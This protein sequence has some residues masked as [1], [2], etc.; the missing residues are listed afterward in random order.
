MAER[1]PWGDTAFIGE[2]MT[3]NG[4]PAWTYRSARY[5]EHE[6]VQLL[7][8]TWLLVGHLS[9]IPMRGD[10]ITLDFENVRIVVIRGRDG[11]VRAFENTCRHMGSRLFEQ[12]GGNCVSRIRCPFHG[13]AYNLE[14]DL[15]ETLD[16][17]DSVFVFRKSVKLRRYPLFER[18][19]LLFV[20]PRVN[21]RP[22]GMPLANLDDLLE[23]YQLETVQML[24]RYTICH[25]YDAN[26][27]MVME[28]D[29]AIYGE[30]GSESPR[31][32]DN[33]GALDLL[34]RW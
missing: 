17:R 13:W 21:Q 15:I 5:Q 1:N 24:P 26:W 20:Y 18:Q 34:V 28:V 16:K 10:F 31:I 33:I 25:Q 7:G 6:S 30:Q 9:E 12:K 3:D 32:S 22:P 27:K 2:A 8:V 11:I 4:L 19:G 23:S 29:A 14:G